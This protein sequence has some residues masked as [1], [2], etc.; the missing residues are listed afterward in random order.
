MKTNKNI[1]K[2]V[3]KKHVGHMESFEPRMMLAVGTSLGED[4]QKALTDDTTWW[5]LGMTTSNP[6]HEVFDKNIGT[7]IKE[8]TQDF[9]LNQESLVS[10]RLG[11]ETLDKLALNFHGTF[12]PALMS[13]SNY[14]V[15]N[16]QGVFNIDITGDNS[17]DTLTEDSFKLFLKEKYKEKTVPEYTDGDADVLTVLKWKRDVLEFEQSQLKK[18]AVS[19]SISE[20]DGTGSWIPY[21]AKHGNEL[22][23]KTFTFSD[24]GTVEGKINEIVR[25]T[26]AIYDKLKAVTV[27]NGVEFAKDA[28]GNTLFDASGFSLNPLQVFLSDIDEAVAKDVVVKLEKLEKSTAYHTVAHILNNQLLGDVNS[29]QKGLLSELNEHY[30]D[31]DKLFD[32]NLKSLNNNIE[33]YENSIK[34][35]N[36]KV[37]TID[38]K[39]GNIIT[40]A[41]W[42]MTGDNNQG[43]QFNDKFFDS[44]NTVLEGFVKSV[45]QVVNEIDILKQNYD[46]AATTEQ[47]YEAVKLLVGEYNNF[48]LEKKVLEGVLKNVDKLTFDNSQL[49]TLLQNLEDALSE[50]ETAQKNV[51]KGSISGIDNLQTSVKEKIEHLKA[52]KEA[53]ANHDQKISDKV[54]AFKKET[55]EAIEKY[56]DLIK[57]KANIHDVLQSAG[58][59]YL[60]DLLQADQTGIAKG[61][62]A[63]QAVDAFERQYENTIKTLTEKVTALNKTYND[64]YNKYYGNTAGGI[65]SLIHDTVDSMV[66]IG[67]GYAQTDE[68]KADFQVIKNGFDI[69]NQEIA[70]AKADFNKHLDVNINGN[71]ENYVRDSQNIFNLANNHVKVIRAVQQELVDNYGVSIQSFNSG[72]FNNLLDNAKQQLDTSKVIANSL[73]GKIMKE[74]LSKALNEQFDELF[75][76]IKNIENGLKYVGVESKTTSTQTQTQS[77]VGDSKV[78]NDDVQKSVN[79]N[80]NKRAEAER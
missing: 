19:V 40:S 13:G 17:L 78:K 6:G 3:T 63:I 60:T 71:W 26:D 52:I 76:G 64:V 34:G 20:G 58:V 35:L 73:L 11:V 22:T 46:N 68:A 51:K 21:F 8:E 37:A 27:P 32:S 69:L 38:G 72:D 67:T 43:H 80:K 15:I 42:F 29:G 45:D 47:K 55:K 54:S 24:I 75:D 48:T 77:Q 16:N 50:I 1:V 62:A 30:N 28:S 9:Q 12:V 18:H 25:D 61:Q 53:Y 23:K 57:A 4:H 74:S 65:G 14:N 70:E 44:Y 59:K 7:V 10:I 5:G 41:D 36:T 31:L 56:D 39:V 66:N 2:R 49:P 79:S 33:A